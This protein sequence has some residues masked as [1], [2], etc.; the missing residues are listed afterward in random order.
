MRAA[1]LALVAL[2]L[3]PGCLERAGSDAPAQS[4]GANDASPF[5]FRVWSTCNNCGLDVGESRVFLA[6]PNGSALLAHG[7]SAGTPG[8]RA[9]NLSDATPADLA[10]L[11]AWQVSARNA[12]PAQGGM[13]VTHVA[14]GNL[15]TEMVRELRDA[16]RDDWTLPRMDPEDLCRA[17]AGPG[18][19]G[20]RANAT[21]ETLRVQEVPTSVGPDT[22][23]GRLLLA[24]QRAESAIALTD[25]QPTSTTPIAATPPPLTK[26]T[27]ND[28]PTTSPGMDTGAMQG[29]DSEFGSI[30]APYRTQAQAGVPAPFQAHVILKSH[31][32]D[33]DARF[34]LFGWTSQTPDV[35]VRGAGQQQGNATSATATPTWLVRSDTQAPIPCAR[36]ET[37]A[38][39]ERCFVDAKDL[40]PAGTEIL[41]RGEA[42][43]NRTVHAQIG[44]T[45]AAFTY[46]WERVKMSNG[47]DAELYAY[48]EL[49]VG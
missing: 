15:S 37:S 46:S 5:A 23:F 14:R 16:L 34:F 28:G 7:V 11:V 40:P 39:G 25:A 31:Y 32:A 27:P 44:L 12:L 35:A 26:P 49:V 4:L 9:A 45:V 22:P 17:C 41:A 2:L 21:W 43:A 1:I 24:F 3:L 48:T 6:W 19:Y 8:I 33:Q 10:A 42:S 20:R 29:Q 30:R 36:H 18:V 47:L 38:E 13:E